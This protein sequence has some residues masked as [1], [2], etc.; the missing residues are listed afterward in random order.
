MELK[1]SSMETPCGTIR[2]FPGEA[3]ASDKVLGPCA[4]QALLL[5]VMESYSRTFPDTIRSRSGETALKAATVADASVRWLHVQ[6]VGFRLPAGIHDLKLS[7]SAFHFSVHNYG[8][9]KK[10]FAR[11]L[12]LAGVKL[13]WM[14]FRL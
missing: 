2:F 3:S 1:G 9:A 7:C 12:C 13:M 14:A 5:R 10:E 8:S 4:L 11:W 6:D